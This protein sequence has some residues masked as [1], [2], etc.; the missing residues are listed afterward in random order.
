MFL[1]CFSDFIVTIVTLSMIGKFG[2][3]TSFLVIYVFTAELYP[4]PVR[5]VSVGAGSFFARI[6][7]VIAPYVIELVSSNS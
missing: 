6:G 3:S 2:I 4:T 1:I 5:N 7:G